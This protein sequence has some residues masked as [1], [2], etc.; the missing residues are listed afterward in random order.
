MLALGPAAG[1]PLA[2][3]TTHLVAHLELVAAVLGQQHAVACLK[4]HLDAR[5]VLAQGAGADGHDLGL[6]LLLLRRVGQ[7][8]VAPISR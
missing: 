8:C 7:V 4:D 1:S 3:E 2:G 5:T 6:N